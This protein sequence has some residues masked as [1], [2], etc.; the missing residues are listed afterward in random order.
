MY[1]VS[2]TSHEQGVYI[3]RGGNPDGIRLGQPARWTLQVCF[4]RNKLSVDWLFSGLV[5]GGLQL[6]YRPAFLS[7][8]I[9]EGLGS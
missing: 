2:A 1:P 6:E 4:V 7:D 5:L 8:S 3:S 9:L